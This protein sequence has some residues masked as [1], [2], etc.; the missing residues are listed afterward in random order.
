MLLQAG[1]VNSV[2]VWSGPG[3]KGVTVWAGADIKW[4]GAIGGGA[5]STTHI[6]RI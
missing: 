2:M 6:K 5:H 1:A 3:D 4:N